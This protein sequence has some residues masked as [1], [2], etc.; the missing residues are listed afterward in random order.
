MLELAV[1]LISI[2]IILLVIYHKNNTNNNISYEGFDNFYLSSCPSGYKSFYNNDGNIV[3]CDGEIV[4]NKCLSDNQC[5]L[6]GSGTPQLPNCTTLIQKMYSVKSKE[7][8]SSSLPNYFEDISKNIKGCMSGSLNSTMTGPKDAK[9]P[10]C[11]IYPSVEQNIN[12]KDSCSNQK[13]LD[14][15]PCFGNNCT[16]E[17]VQPNVKA[18]PLVA[19]G[20]T[21]TSGMHRMAYTKQSMENFLNVINKNW[22]NQGMDL[23]KNLNIAEVAKAFYV[24]KTLSQSDVQI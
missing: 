10:T 16:K 15:A 11:Y 7:Y 13:Q 1:L 12:A 21:D 18:P 3:C 9:Q 24:D 8:C 20:F 2:T 6:N 19:I 4:A 17:I 5:T 23:S 14:L 22:Q